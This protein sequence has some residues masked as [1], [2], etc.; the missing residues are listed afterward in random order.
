ME[1]IYPPTMQCKVP[2]SGWGRSGITSV[3]NII[4][5]SLNWLCQF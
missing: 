5:L 1:H 2:L 4:E 3:V